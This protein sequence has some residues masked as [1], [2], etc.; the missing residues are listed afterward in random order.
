MSGPLQGVKIIEMAGLGPGPFC[1]MM[2][3][4]MGADVVRV[5]AKAGGSPIA[6]PHPRYDVTARGRRSIAV[7]LKA[8]AGTELVLRLIEQS[9]ALIEGFR[10][11]VMERLGLGPDVCL[12]RNPRLVFGRMTGWGQTGPLANAAGHDLNY[13]ALTGVLHAMGRAHEPPPVPLNLVG[14]YGGGAMM[15]AFG[16]VCAL[17][18]AQRSG[19][20][21]VIDAAM[22]DGAALLASLMFGLKSA[23]IWHP[24]RASNFLDGAAHFYDTFECADGKF[25]AIAALEPHFFRQLCERL[26]IET[27]DLRHH[28]D[29][30]AWPSLK[31]RITEVIRSQT[32]DHWCALLEGTDTCFA[33]VLDWDEAIAHP[34]NHARKTFIEV[35]GVPQPAPAP[36]LSRTPAAVQRP[37][38]ARGEHTDAVLSDYGISADEIASLRAQGVL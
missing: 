14:D 35:D 3:S 17:F 12:S 38:A 7:D 30:A 15:L 31:Q 1:G 33:P 37:P 16:M 27:P 8:A 2:L 18:E 13:I 25:V 36:R 10:P 29:A 22:T 11:G 6:F 19:Q 32:R 24:Q 9:D 34:H 28:L 20:G 26:G 21:Q 5:D 4:D 23:G